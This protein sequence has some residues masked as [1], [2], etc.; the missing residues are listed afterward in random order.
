MECSLKANRCAKNVKILPQTVRGG[1]LY[2]TKHGAI[3]AGIY[4]NPNLLYR[5]RM[6]SNG[7]GVVY[8]HFKQVRRQARGFQA[9]E[10]VQA[11][12]SLLWPLQAGEEEEVA[13]QTG[14]SY[15]NKGSRFVSR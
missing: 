7:C 14:V 3:A 10:V 8:Q 13:V 12:P 5:I 4:I 1:Q 6:T 15:F 9:G 11:R 2:S